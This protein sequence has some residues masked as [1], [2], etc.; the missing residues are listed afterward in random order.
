M[1]SE[2]KRGD[3]GGL[4]KPGRVIA[5]KPQEARIRFEE[6]TRERTGVVMGKAMVITYT[7]TEKREEGGTPQFPF[8]PLWKTRKKRGK[9]KRHINKSPSN[10]LEVK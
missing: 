1:K 10:K 9:K 5:Q 6:K 4:E 8:P 2:E 3:E 7:P